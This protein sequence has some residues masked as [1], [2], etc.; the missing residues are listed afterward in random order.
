MLSKFTGKLNHPRA[1]HL[2]NRLTFGIDKATIDQFADMTVDEAWS[3]IARPSGFELPAPPI[4]PQTGMTWIYGDD[5]TRN[6]S[7][8]GTPNYLRNSYVAGWFIDELY[9]YPP[10]LAQK[11]VY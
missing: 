1:K 11:L 9:N 10:H 7:S 4:D 2:L 5:A 8:N 6:S 3:F